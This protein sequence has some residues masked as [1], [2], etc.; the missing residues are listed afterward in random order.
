MIDGSGRRL[1][2]CFLPWR[3]EASP[4]RGWFLRRK[5]LLRPAAFVFS[6][7]QLAVCG[8]LRH[9]LAPCGRWSAP[10]LLSE[11]MTQLRQRLSDLP[12]RPLRAASKT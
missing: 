4:R 6:C 11:P 1:A 12:R 8:D 9:D 10:S 5:R 3:G 2:A 7:R